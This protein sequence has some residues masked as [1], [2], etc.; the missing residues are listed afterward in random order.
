MR[1]IIGIILALIGIATTAFGI[2]FKVKEQ[3]SV[4]IDSA[5]GATSIFVAG[6]FGSTPIVIGFIIIGIVLFATGI[7]MTLSKVPKAS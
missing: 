2:I 5:D 3:M 1:K 4:V 6:K 7:F